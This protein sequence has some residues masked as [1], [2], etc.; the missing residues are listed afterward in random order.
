MNLQQ[1]DF[2]AD[3]DQ[4]INN[5]N[6]DPACHN[7]K[8]HDQFDCGAKLLQ[9]AVKRTESGT[10]RRGRFSEMETDTEGSN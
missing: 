1:S 7:Q 10:I 3:I 4:I 9:T 2:F 8:S 5:I 6:P